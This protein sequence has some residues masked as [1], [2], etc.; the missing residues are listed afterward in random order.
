MSAARFA[1]IAFVAACA[2]EEPTTS[3]TVQEA[4]GWND[5]EIWGC[6]GNSSIV[7]QFGITGLPMSINTPTAEGWTITKV[8][9]GPWG[10]TQYTFFVQNA[11]VTAVP[12]GGGNTLSGAAAVGLV[13]HL[14]HTSGA[15]Y[16]L[17]LSARGRTK[18]WAQPS[19]PTGLYT[20][21]YEVSWD[22]ER[23]PG[24]IG[25]LW[26]NVCSAPDPENPDNLNMNPY[27]AV[28][29]EGDRIDAD[30]KKITTTDSTWFNIGCAGHALAKLHLTGHSQAA[31]NTFPELLD[32]SISQRTTMLKM[33]TADYCGTGHSF[34][35]PGEPLQ[36]KDANGWM[37]YTT[38]TSIEARLNRL[39]ATCL[40]APRLASVSRTTVDSHCVA[41]GKPVIPSCATADG[42][43]DPNNLAGKHLVSANPWGQ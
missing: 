14:Q 7:D 5:C 25:A 21:A 34:T 32:T 37:G 24:A 2:F 41:N 39:G 38:W 26:K 23:P 9:F 27:Y 15:K 28:L 42:S 18:F 29:F 36:W 3:E 8:T 31:E 10:Q 20:W 17:H 33:L 4:G 11:S 1:S 12:I 6:G 43:T 40:Q 22:F 30:L 19:A 13:F 35:A 16:W